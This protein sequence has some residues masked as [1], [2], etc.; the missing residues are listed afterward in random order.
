V[1]VNGS[2][3][4]T[5]GADSHPDDPLG[6]DQT[7][8]LV[9]ELPL[10]EIAAAVESDFFVVVEAGMALPLAGDLDGDGLADTTDN[11]ANGRVNDGDVAGRFVEPGRV[12][13]DD[14]RFYVQ[15]VAPGVLPLAFSNPFF[16]DRN[17]DG[18]RGRRQR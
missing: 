18:F 13:R 9:T 15:S 6:R 4:A 2:L 7:S 1:L 16:I 12:P 17:G 3:F 8:R 11:D 5:I 10:S 14:P